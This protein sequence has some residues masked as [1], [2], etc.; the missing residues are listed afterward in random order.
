ML[1]IHLG[2][3]YS[4]KGVLKTS[5]SLHLTKFCRTVF[6][7]YRVVVIFSLLGN[8]LQF[9]L[10]LVLCLFSIQMIQMLQMMQSLIVLAYEVSSLTIQSY[11]TEMHEYLTPQNCSVRLS[12]IHYGIQWLI[13]A[14]SLCKYVKRTRKL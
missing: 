10:L 4:A 9:G 13:C 12:P 7:L 2:K 5:I 1:C 3:K 14:P 6:L 8:V 11:P